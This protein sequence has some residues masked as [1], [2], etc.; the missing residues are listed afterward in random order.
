MDKWVCKRCGNE[1]F[2][3]P[4]KWGICNK[5]G[6]KGRFRRHS[7]CSICGE[8]F[9]NVGNGRKRCDNCSYSAKSERWGLVDLV[10]DN[11][12]I[13][14]KRYKGNISGKFNNYCSKQCML[15]HKKA[16][17]LKRTC[18]Y[19][20]KEFEVYRSVIEKSNASGNYCCRECYNEDMTLD[21]ERV[22]TGFAKSK[23]ENFSKKQFCAI[24]GT[25][26]KIHIHHIMPNRIT[27][28]QS[29]ENLIPLCATCHI[30]IERLT[31]DFLKE[32]EG[33]YEKAE[34]LLRLILRQ[35]QFE[36]SLVIKEILNGNRKNKNK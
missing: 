18:K 28:D 11:C 2:E 36:T 24:C 5:D 16:D 13:T 20:G 4:T 7:Q 26:K 15:E 6:C 23:R 33:E 10:C 21:K 17:V 25:T 34:P 22:Y 1:V 31:R 29:K 35:R 14:F 19:C 12:G 3:N 30:K 9:L 27:H 32:F 8:W